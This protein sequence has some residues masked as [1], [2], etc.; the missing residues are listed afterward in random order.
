MKFLCFSETT[1]PADVL[2][3]AFDAAVRSAKMKF[4]SM[5]SNICHTKYESS[6]Q[7]FQNRWC[8]DDETVLRVRII[9]ISDAI[10]RNFKVK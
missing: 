5:N 6:N 9:V 10:V 3:N 2:T 1:Q 4:R 8:L 7:V